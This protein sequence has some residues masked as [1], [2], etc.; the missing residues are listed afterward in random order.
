ML[1]TEDRALVARL[2]PGAIVK[3]RQGHKTVALI[4]IEGNAI[5][6]VRVLNP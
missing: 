1:R 6:P 2:E 5:R 3:S 4:R